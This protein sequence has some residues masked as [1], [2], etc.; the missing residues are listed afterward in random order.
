MGASR[1][2][3]T[4]SPPAWIEARLGAV[5]VT[6][7]RVYLITDGRFDEAADAEAP[8]AVKLVRK[9]GLPAAAVRLIKRL[10]LKTVGVQREHI[11]LEMYE[12]LRSRLRP[13]RLV[14]APA[15]VA[16]LR[17]CKDAQEVEHLRRAV[18]VAQAAFRAAVRALRVGMS[19]GQLAARLEFEMRRRGAS[20]ASFPIIVAAD[21]NSSRPHARAGDRPI[22]AGGAVLLDWG[23]QVGGYCS[24][25]TRMLFIGR[26]PPR[27]GR[28]YRVVRE[29]QRRAIET[30][31]PGVRMCEVDAAAR[32]YIAKAGLGAYFVHS[33]GHGLGLEVH[34]APRLDRRSKDRLEPGMVFT[35]EPGVY[36]PGVG[37][38]RIEDDVLVTAD[39]CEV[40][41]DLPK[42]MHP[43]RL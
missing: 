22:R 14:A 3:G 20:R 43:L 26:I 5:L 25:L 41:S 30:I 2:R 38:V 15:I 24:D 17:V 36:L 4:V 19:E 37:G 29:A 13:R 16:R 1:K 31:R 12:A 39:G 9:T 8:W 28:L 18:R 10:D 7:R 34:E 42:D 33:L 6:P 27:F 35:V 11:C 40:L 32:S 21:A 23:A